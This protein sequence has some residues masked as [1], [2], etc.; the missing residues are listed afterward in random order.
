MV[1]NK[2]TK[3]PYN[4][5]T[6]ERAR[7]N[8]PSTWVSFEEASTAHMC[9]GIG[10]FFTPPYIGID[11][12]N[13]G[14][15][16]ERYKAGDITDNIVAEFYEAFKS[17]GEV[18]PS[19]QGVHIITKG[20]IPGTRRRRNNVEMYQEGRFFTMTG[21]TL[22][23]YSKVTPASD[24]ELKRIYK[25][26][27][28]NSDNIVY[29]RFKEPTFSHN[30]STAEVV[31]KIL[32]SKQASMFKVFMNGGWESYYNNDQSAADL[33]FANLLAFWTAKDYTQMDELFRKSSLY[34]PKWD[35]K[36]GKVSYGEMTLNKAIH[37]T[38]QTFI[39]PLEKPKYYFS[40]EFHQ[41]ESSPKEYPK[42]SY[43]D[44]GNA[45]RLDDRFGDIISYI[46]DF[47]KFMIYNGQHWREDG[48][49][50][51]RK[52]IDLMIED[53]KNEPIHVADP[54]DEELVKEAEKALRKH[55]KDS[56]Q[57]SKK[58]NIVDEMQHRHSQLP[59][60]FDK[61]DMLANT[62]NGVLDLTSGVI[63][64]HDPKYMMSKITETEISEYAPDI[65]LDFLNDIFDGDN[66]MIDFMQRAL[67]YSLTGS[68]RE[69][70]MF[71]LHG[72]GRNG[73]SLFVETVSEILG[74]YSR[75]IRASS[76]MAKKDSGV[77]DD[78]AVLQGA[79]FVTSS[80]PNEGFRFDEGLIKQLTGGDTIT[81]RFLY[82]T[83]FEFEPKFKLWLTTNHK[84]YVRGTDDGIWRRLLLVPFE[85][86]IP[87]DKVDKDLK[88]K[89]LRESPGI[90]NWILEGA[91]KW[92]RDGLKIP[93][94]IIEQ[95]QAYRFEMDIVAQFI[96]AECVTGE[97]Y[98]VKANELYK[99]YIQWANEN[100]YYRF[101]HTEF[102]QKMVEKFERKRTKKGNLYSGLEIKQ[103][104]PG[105]KSLN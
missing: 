90:L 68:T 22:R 41:P 21:D 32:Q 91:V 35:E 59:N 39:P 54:N 84:P 87:E 94:K 43:D 27:L 7:S 31:E 49:G 38:N 77:G 57:T 40:D 66:E 103:K 12:D 65:W 17:Y 46:Y 24:N 44:T 72:R 104:Y 10:F 74:D 29:P 37:D 25:K 63:L 83:D 82:G 28:D 14:G 97:N 9:D 99:A 101:N 86:Q 88:Y 69:Q 13:V 105:L 60:D 8:D 95:S 75:T 11:L 2:E 47:K 67:G 73:K 42:R 100:G 34:R 55:I 4:P 45:D 102:G 56:R 1:G 53:M 70:V 79:R 6:G 36:R 5:V 52:L 51:I 19:G 96:D 93:K 58:R 3:I 33:A 48:T 15:D 80:E 71:I 50:E 61:D 30:L 98:S 78:I 64:E 20:K 26:Y 85:V 92:Q 16:I 23:K 18:S 81:A 89:L 62:P 76:L